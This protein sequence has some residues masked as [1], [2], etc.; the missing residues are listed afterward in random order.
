MVVNDEPAPEDP[1]VHA[2]CNMSLY[3]GSRSLTGDKCEEIADERAEIDIE[4][5]TGGQGVI[6]CLRGRWGHNQ[7]AG[8]TV[9]GGRLP[10]TT[11][12]HAWL[13]AVH[14]KHTCN[15]PVFG[16]KLT[17]LSACQRLG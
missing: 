1:C 16:D 2:A 9:G 13:F 6:G 14:Y 7:R 4:R 5:V 12:L 15:L 3:I 10:D 8:N 17:Q 11:P